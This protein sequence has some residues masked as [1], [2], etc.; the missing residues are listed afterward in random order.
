M[1]SILRLLMNN[2]KKVLTCVSLIFILINRALIF[3][4]KFYKD[5]L[6][7]EIKEYLDIIIHIFIDVL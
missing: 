3:I 2:T 7:Y 6:K 5:M 4:R 1:T